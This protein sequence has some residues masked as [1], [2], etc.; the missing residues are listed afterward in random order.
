MTG[1]T[2]TEGAGEAVLLA[3]LRHV[4]HVALDMDGTIYCGSRLFPETPP[5]LEA[6]QAQHIGVSFLTNNSSKS[7]DDYVAHLRKLGIAA[8]P[9]DVF[10]SALATMELVRARYPQLQRVFVVGTPSLRSEISAAG[11]EVLPADSTLEPEA[12]IVGF[13][14]A[15]DYP[16]LCKAAYWIAQGLPY[17]ATHPDRI[18]PTN[19]PTLLLDCGAI[20]AAI[21]SA[22]GRT[23]EIVG[24]KPE[25]GMIH[26]LCRRL[27]LQPHQVAMVGDRLYTDVAMAKRA[28]ALGV[29]TLTG[30]TQRAHLPNAEVT[31]DLVVENLAELAELLKRSV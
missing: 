28:G 27:G 26:A 15:L 21:E 31:P 8:R 13:D 20:C 11:F 18:C 14:T 19:Q 9:E 30:E 16:T 3:R 4:R 5:F 7:V 24:G 17:F 12:V 6:L 10:T 22:T 2:H 1:E 23:P 29:L 25:P